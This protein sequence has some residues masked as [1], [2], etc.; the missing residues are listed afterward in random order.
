MN[1]TIGEKELLGIVE[2]F[3]AFEGF[4]RGVE[5]TVHTDHLN[6]L[7]RNLSSQ[8]MVQWRLF[9]KEYHPLFKPPYNRVNHGHNMNVILPTVLIFYYFWTP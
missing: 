9:L 4:L 8:R 2:G 3:K 5:V 6:L 1:Y 7:Y